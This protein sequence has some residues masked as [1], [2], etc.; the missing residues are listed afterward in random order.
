MTTY[1]LS[2]LNWILFL[3]EMKAYYVVQVLKQSINIKMNCPNYTLEFRNK[4]SHLLKVY[5]GALAK[6]ET[7]IENHV[8]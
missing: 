6:I 7:V 3:T 1:F 2:V 8:C 5:L 4:K